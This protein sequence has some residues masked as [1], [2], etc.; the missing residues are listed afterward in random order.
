MSADA[1]GPGIKRAIVL[2]GGGARG[3]YEAGVLRFLLEELPRRMGHPVKFDIVCG[4]SVGAIHACFLGA[5]AEQGTG[6]GMR[7]LQLWEHLKVDEVFHF[8]SSNLISLPRKILGL[9]RVAQRLREGQRPD[10]LYGILDTE[11]LERL[12]LDSIPWRGIRRN[13]KAGLIEAVCVATTQVATGRAVVFVEQAHRNLPQWG[14]QDN[15]RMQPIR[16]SPMHAL[17]SAAIPMLFPAVR[18]GA[19]YYADGGLRL[20]TPLAPAVRLGANRVLVIGV[21]RGAYDEVDE[22]LAQQRVEGYGNPMFLLGKVLNALMLSPVEA[23]LARLHFIN[24]IIENGSDTFGSDFLE[25][26]NRASEAKGGRPLQ[27]IDDLVIRPSVDLGMLAGQVLADPGRELELSPFLRLFIRAFGTGAEVRE[28]DLL[29][30]LLFDAAYAKPLAEIGYAD[31][32][33]QEN[34]LATFFS[35]APMS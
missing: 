15:I 28:S 32:E 4:T 9:R 7:L 18:L 19:R 29:S 8:S 35:D 11:P 30:Y 13:L 20:N 22:G 12:V 25:K 31:A 23:D 27:R 26:M 34:E 21:G 17:A 16:L 24:N 1:S 33:A 6:R 10:R 2:A 3:A 5:T 14:G